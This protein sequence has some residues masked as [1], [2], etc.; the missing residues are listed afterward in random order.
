MN[1]KLDTNIANILFFSSF[2]PATLFGR[3]TSGKLVLSFR[4]SH[5]FVR[6]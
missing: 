3:P 6:G 5:I 4:R 1:S 2:K